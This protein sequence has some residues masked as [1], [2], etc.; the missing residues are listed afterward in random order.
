MPRS[1]RASLS[2]LL[3]RARAGSHGLG[4]RPRSR[5]AVGGRRPPGQQV[6]VAPPLIPAP[7]TASKIK[8]GSNIASE[9]CADLVVVRRIAVFVVDLTIAERW[10]KEDPSPPAVT[11][12]CPVALAALFR[13]TASLSF[14]IYA[15]CGGGAHI[16]LG[17]LLDV[18]ARV[19]TAGSELCFFV[20]LF[21]TLSA[22]VLRHRFGVVKGCCSPASSRTSR[23]LGT[24]VLIFALRVTVL[25]EL[26]L[27]TAARHCSACRRANVHVASSQRFCR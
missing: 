1:R 21:L 22:R 24:T 16:L 23:R 13:R 12:R 8:T 4:R 27:T 17:E 10:A 18:G 9:G 14:P 6:R 5:L 26:R 15:F 11:P 7:W 20:L 3:R 25:G 2:S 19:N